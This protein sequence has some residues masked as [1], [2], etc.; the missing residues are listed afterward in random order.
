[1][2]R[3]Q[4]EVSASY[5]SGP[6]DVAA[7]RTSTAQSREIGAELRR[8]RQ[9]AGLK[10]VHVAGEL[11]W[12]VA[13]L[14]K[15]EKGWR[16]TTDWDIG[17][18]LG[19]CGADKVDRDRIIHLVH[20]QR[21]GYFTRSHQVGFPD[22]LLSLE[23]HER[24]ATKITSYDPVSIPALAQAEAYALALL[25]TGSGSKEANIKMVKSRVD[26]SAR[27]CRENFPSSVF[28]IHENALDLKVGSIDTMHDQMMWLTFLSDWSQ[29][30]LR[31]I[32][33]SAGGHAALFRPV[34]L[35]TFED[36]TSLAYTDADM[37]TTFLETDD[38]IEFY[39]RKLDVL[40][41][42]ALDVDQSRQLLEARADAYERSSG[43]DEP[44]R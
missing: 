14:S 9:R 40:D 24:I 27:V 42:M 29:V 38:A 35:L 16:A 8:V 28:Y 11:G 44:V 20:E 26:R 34:T 22:T 12:S 5:G 19:K 17:T 18:L 21:L 7:V 31:V 39:H 6:A 13:K 36:A 10:T 15:L 23:I 41:S 4:S 37:S 25:S 30:R 3:E 43:E 1:M 32:L 2:A 33:R